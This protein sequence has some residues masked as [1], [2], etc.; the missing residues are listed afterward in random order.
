[1]SPVA[2]PKSAPGIIE[3]DRASSPF[4]SA[5]P[6]ALYTSLSQTGHFQGE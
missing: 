5:T 4:Q 2:R 6:L 3:D 1:M